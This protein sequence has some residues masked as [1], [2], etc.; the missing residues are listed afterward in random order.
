MAT[1]RRRTY[2]D[3]GTHLHPMTLIDLFYFILD[4]HGDLLEVWDHSR[5]RVWCGCGTA[6]QAY[7]D[8]RTLRPTLMAAPPCV[9]RC[10]SDGDG[11]PSRVPSAQMELDLGE[12]EIEF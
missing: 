3:S 7:A 9:T 6:P 8:A 12:R 4:Q 11:E 2:L 1:R 10:R 5:D